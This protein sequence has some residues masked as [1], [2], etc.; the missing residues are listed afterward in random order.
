MN[1]LF[2]IIMLLLPSLF[3]AAN[4][5][6]TVGF[7][8]PPEGVNQA[9]LAKQDYG[10]ISTAGAYQLPV[11]TINVYRDNIRHKLSI[12]DAGA[13]RKFAIKWVKSNER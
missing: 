6:V 7:N 8:L 5:S 12:N 11:K 1:K 3:F 2:I 10:F 4:L 13:L 9:A